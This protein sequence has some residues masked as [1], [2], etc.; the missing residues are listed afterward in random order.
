MRTRCRDGF[1]GAAPAAPFAGSPFAARPIFGGGAPR[2]GL[3]G[4]PFP[5]NRPLNLDWAFV[6][7]MTGFASSLAG[8]ALATAFAFALAGFALRDADLEAFPLRLLFAIPRLAP[9]LQR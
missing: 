9:Y 1:F 4:R 2:P 8:F 6:G 3:P 5:L 7:F